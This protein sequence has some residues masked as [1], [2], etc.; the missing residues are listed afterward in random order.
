MSEDRVLE[1]EAF[2]R[3]EP[4]RGRAA[5]FPHRIP[6]MGWRD[7]FWRSFWEVSRDKLP[8]TAGGVTFYVLLAIFPAIAAFVSLYGLIS[9]VGAVEQQLRELSGV[10]PASVIQIVGEQMLR[11]AG[12]HP[13]KLSAA[14]L[15]SLLVSVWSANAGMKALFEGL[16]V[17]YDETEK[18]PFFLRTAITYGSTFGALVFLAVVA[19]VLVAAPLA[20]KAIG[21]ARFDTIWIPLRWMAVAL[22]SSI[23]FSAVYRYGP[24][25][26]RAQWRWVT[27]GA[28]LASAGW[29]GGSLGFSWYVNNVAHF[30]ATYGPLGAVVGFMLWVW[31]SVMCLLIGAEINAEIEHQT[32]IDSTI[33]AEKPMGERGAAMADTVGQPFHLRETIRR[34][35]GVAQRQA[36]GLWNRARGSTAG[37]RQR[38]RPAP[39]PPRTQAP[40]G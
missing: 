31:F 11:L 19:A 27:W 24:S 22:V 39:T 18:R 14:F 17:A 15:L 12:Q 30:D 36:G 6:L 38:G 23:A 13:G 34:G 21:F 9:D 32:A 3:V 29:L 7:I 10:F 20:M 16:N 26:T 5:R 28:L 37:L 40:R 1:P 4:G 8:S 25:R 2:D 35:A 33:G